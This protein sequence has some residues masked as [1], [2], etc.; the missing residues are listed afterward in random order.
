MTYQKRLKAVEFKNKNS[1]TTLFTTHRWDFK[2]DTGTRNFQGIAVI[3][4]YL[5]FNLMLSTF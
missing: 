4:K 3:E 1:F 2:M 5:I